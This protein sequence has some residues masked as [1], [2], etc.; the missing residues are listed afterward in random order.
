[1]YSFTPEGIASQVKFVRSMIEDAKRD[2]A[3][4]RNSDAVRKFAANQIARWETELADLASREGLSAMEAYRRVAGEVESRNVQKRMKM[5][6]EER[7]ATPPWKTEDVPRD[8]QIVNM[9]RASVYGGPLA[10]VGA[11]KETRKAKAYHAAYEPFDK[12]DWSRLGE[13]TRPNAVGGAQEEFAMNLAQL[14]PWASE[15]DVAAEDGGSAQSACRDRR[16][17]QGICLARQALCVHSQSWWI[18]GGK[19]EVDGCWL[20]PRRG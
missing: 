10:G 4:P 15:K 12:F 11:M 2:I 16:Q 18:R 6:P 3:D 14:G 5:T 13:T 17:R 9:N 7:R 1:M 20:W 19:E 8:K